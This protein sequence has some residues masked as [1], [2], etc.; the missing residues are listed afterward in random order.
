MVI[1]RSLSDL[2]QRVHFQLFCTQRVHGCN[3]A[4]YQTG[5]AIFCTLQTTELFGYQTNSIIKKKY[6][7]LKQW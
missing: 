3:F 4:F 5:V 2:I 1:E 7:C 6:C